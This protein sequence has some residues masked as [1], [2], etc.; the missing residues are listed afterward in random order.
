M[1]LP[2]KMVK[3]FVY[4]HDHSNGKDSA[5]EKWYDTKNEITGLCNVNRITF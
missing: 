4:V 2:L 3:M 1:L 5:Y